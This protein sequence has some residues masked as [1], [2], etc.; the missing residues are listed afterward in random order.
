MAHLYTLSYTVH[1]HIHV[2]GARLCLWI[3]PTNGPIVNPQVVYVYGEPRWNDTDREN[4]RTRTKICPSATPSTTNTIWTDPGANSSLRDEKPATN[5]PSHGT[6][7]L[8][9]TSLYLSVYFV[10]LSQLQRLCSTE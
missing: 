3:A 4:R 7:Y 5:H 1:A 2:R 10:T 8:C 9:I 6:A